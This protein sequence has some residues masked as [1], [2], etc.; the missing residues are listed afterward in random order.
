MTK[1]VHSI[2]PIQQDPACLLKWTWSS[3]FFNSGSTASCHRTQHYPIDPDNFAEFHNTPEKL[4]AR[5]QMLEGQWPGKGCQYCRDTELAGGESDRMMQ[6]RAMTDITLSPPELLHD[7]TATKVTPTMLEV[8]FNNTCNMKCVYCG[9]YHSSQ[10]EQENRKFQNSFDPGQDEYAITK[11]QHNPHYEKMVQELWTYLD[12]EQRYRNLRRFSILGGEPFLI[13]EIDQCIDFWFDHPNPDVT[14]S[15]VTN[16][17]VPHSRFLQYMEKFDSLVTTGKIMTVTIVGSLDAWG[18]EQ[19]YTRY[20]INLDLWQKNFEAILTNPNITCS[21]NSTMSALTMKQMYMLLEKINQW[22]TQ[23]ESIA[24]DDHNRYIIHSFNTTGKQDNLYY[25]DRS[26][27]A[28]DFEKII[29]LMPDKSDIQRNHK[30]AM[31]GIAQRH[32]RC[33]NNLPKISELQKYLTALDSRRNTNWRLT[34]PWL[35][36]DFAV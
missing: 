27:F 31:I 35:D 32:G 10:W 34:F 36:K 7:S 28:S 1:Q 13:S 22:N 30:N 25:F 24:I 2:F 17:N 29:D 26:V 33:K 16:L 9:P 21:I 18:P 4:L 20:G 5:Q 3:I 11:P 19:E 15:I 14:I 23:R 6:L 12:T 8:W